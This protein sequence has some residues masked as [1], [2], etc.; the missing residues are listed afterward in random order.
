MQVEEEAWPELAC[1]LVRFESEQHPDNVVVVKAL[2][3]LAPQLGRH[4]VHVLP[5]LLERMQ[6]QRKYGKMCAVFGFFYILIV[7][8]LHPL[9]GML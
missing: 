7:I 2:T 5:P 3:R 1:A 9:F 8:S 6:T 4:L